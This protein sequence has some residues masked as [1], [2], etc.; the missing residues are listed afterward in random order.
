MNYECYICNTTYPDTE[1][2]CP[3]CKAKKVAIFGTREKFIQTNREWIEKERTKFLRSTEIGVNVNVYKIENGK[4]SLEKTYPV[5]FGKL[6]EICGGDV[7]WLSEQFYSVSESLV[8][9][10]KTE[11]YVNT[12]GKT[13]SRVV[14]VPNPGESDSLTLGISVNPSYAFSLAVKNSNGKITRSEEMPIFK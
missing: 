4:A 8:P 12:G 13:S 7:K 10:L 5:S 14:S 1:T 2:Q 9:R 11:L 6:G 3:V